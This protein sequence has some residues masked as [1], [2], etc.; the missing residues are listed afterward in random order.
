MAIAT[1]F[2]QSDFVGSIKLDFGSYSDF[3]DFAAQVQDEYLRKL[4]GFELYYDYDQN[5]G[6][7]KYDNL[8]DGIAAGY[9]ESGVK[10]ELRGLKKML[11]YFFYFKYQLDLQSFQTTI[12]EFEGIAENATKTDLT[13]PTLTK[14]MVLA[15]NEG[16]AM[17]DELIN[18]ITLQRTEQG[19]SYYPG[20][21]P[22]YLTQ[23]NTF[24]I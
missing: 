2:T 20:F 4:L 12:S 7:T 22:T 3:T 10:K 18:Y 23:Q 1:L 19:D 17:Y 21:L 6:T 15:Y 8:E 16:L 11:P 24:G 13:R 5:Q 9:D 14:N